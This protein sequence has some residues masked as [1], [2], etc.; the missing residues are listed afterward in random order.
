VQLTIVEDAI[1]NATILAA[2]GRVDSN[3]SK[4]LGDRLT[5]LFEA[6]TPSVVIDLGQLLYISSAGFRILLIA[7]RL[8][9]SRGASLAL[10]G[11]SPDVRRLFDL[12]QFSQL[13]PIFASRDE[14]VRQT[15]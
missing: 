5:S 9:D 8:A 10:C 15:R 13:F 11:L 6:G 2:Q 3:T 4:Q 1:G 14:A 12:G 7:A